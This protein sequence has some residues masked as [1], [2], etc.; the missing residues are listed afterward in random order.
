MKN[1]RFLTL[2]AIT[3]TL[4]CVL[5]ACNFGGDKPE[6]QVIVEEEDTA[7][8]TPEA[9]E[10]PEPT[11]APEVWEPTYT[12]QDGSISI[13][14]PDEEWSNKT[15]ANDIVSV[16]SDKGRI[17]IIHGDQEDMETLVLPDSE[18]MANTLER[19][20]ELE[21]GEYELSDYSNED[22]NGA[23]VIY[24]TVKYNNTE[25]TDGVA[26]EIIKYISND[27]E[28]YELNAS[29]NTDDED[30]FAKALA[31]INSFKIL[32]ADSSLSGAAQGAAAAPDAAAGEDVLE[33]GEEGDVV[34]AEP[35]EG[36]SAGTPGSYTDEDLADNNRTR[37]IYSNDGS[38]RPIVVVNNDDGTWSDENGN[39]YRFDSSDISIVYDQDDVDYY[40]GGEAGDVRF[41]PVNAEE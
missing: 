23:N 11:E 6:E 4:S 39:L 7:T 35:V 17:V 38:G 36:T 12:S 2:V 32:S 1:K 13:D 10:E 31:A 15:D 3:A 25:K 24:Y 5:S 37:T 40:Y 9:A 22:Q 29:L 21:D 34:D 8:P 33:S 19:A 18:D 26:R 27:T 28:Y 16:E 41:M 14:L 30:T 20:K